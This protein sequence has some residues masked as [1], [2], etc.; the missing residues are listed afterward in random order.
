MDWVSERLSVPG[1]V[2]ADIAARL[3]SWPVGG[4]QGLDSGTRRRHELV[5]G[6]AVAGEPERCASGGREPRDEIR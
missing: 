4:H 3:L 2:Q 5:S 6:V 1:L